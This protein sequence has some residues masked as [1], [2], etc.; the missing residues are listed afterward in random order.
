MMCQEC[1]EKPASLHFTKIINGEKTEFHLCESCA[2]DKGELL[3]GGHNGFSIHH[4]LSG[5]LNFG[6]GDQ[7][8]AEA[9]ATPNELRCETCGLTYK[10]FSKIGRFGCSDCY[11]HFESVLEP[12]FRRVHGNT[13]HSGKVPER[14]GGKLKR[15]RELAELREK[16]QHLVA[17]EEF[18]EAAAVRDQIRVLENDSEA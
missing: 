8:K 2:R 14:T 1:G 15:K 16:L 5:M 18:E 12:L 10:Q 3:P 4:L 11:H 17:R 13:A 9:K 7:K 6:Y